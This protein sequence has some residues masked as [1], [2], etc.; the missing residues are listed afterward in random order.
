MLNL[1]YTFEDTK[2]RRPL[3]GQRLKAWSG[4]P[5]TP[6]IHG[7]WQ[8]APKQVTYYWFQSLQSLCL[9]FQT[10]IKNLRYHPTKG[11]LQAQDQH[12][13]QHIVL[14]GT[15]PSLVPDRS[16]TLVTTLLQYDVTFAA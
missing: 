16:D 15:T 9:V 7:V 2:F 13:Q 10:W 1:T 12:H 3:F 11:F 5:N 8:Q 6:L 14:D 4:L